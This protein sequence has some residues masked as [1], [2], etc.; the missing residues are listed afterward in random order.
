MQSKIKKIQ[1]LMALLFIGLLIPFVLQR[2]FYPLL[3]FGMFAEPVRDSIQTETFYVQVSQGGA[4]TVFNPL[5]LGIYPATFDYWLRNYHYR[6]QGQLLLQQ[7]HQST[8]MGGTW[9]LVR[10]VPPD[11]TVVANQQWP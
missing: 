5:Q 6:Q 11:R 3:R 4:P 10:V 8:G 1:Y 7:L 9:Q 2:N